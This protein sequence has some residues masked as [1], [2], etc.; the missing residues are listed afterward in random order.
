MPSGTFDLAALNAKTQIDDALSASQRIRPLQGPPPGPAPAFQAY[1]QLMPGMPSSLPS[2][3]GMPGTS[4]QAPGFG[5]MNLGANAPV[6]PGNFSVNVG[7][8]PKLAAR[9][10]QMGYSA[11]VGPGQMSVGAQAQNTPG[12]GWAG[13]GFNAGYSMP[14]G[15]GQASLGANFSPAMGLRD[16]SARYNTPGGSSFGA[17]YA[18]SN[19]AVSMQARVPFAKGGLATG[20]AWTRKEGKN[21]EGGLNEKGRASLRAQGHNIKRPVSAEQASKSPRAAARRKSFCA[22]SAGQAKQF[23]DAA[24]DPNSRLNKARRKWDC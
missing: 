6:G 12:S 20:G 19:N 7:L 23:P 18:P 15:G 8:D 13:S 2:Q 3:G 16:L 17:A 1:G 24:R 5:G 11:P 10:A 21:P 4:P 14:M 22:R 9:A